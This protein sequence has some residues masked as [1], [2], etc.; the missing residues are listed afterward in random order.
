MSEVPARSHATI[1]EL[2]GVRALAVLAVLAHHGAYG[3]IPGGFLGV[4][5]FFTLSG[6]LITHL[7]VR[8]WSSCGRID[9][10]LFYARRALRIL[11]PLVLAMGLAWLLGRFD[12]RQGAAPVLAFYANYVD[13]L[14]LGTMLHT[15]SLAVEEQFY[16]AWPLL[17]VL[18]MA[19]G[20][21]RAA[22]AVAAAAFMAA[23]AF[24]LHGLAAG[25]DPEVIYRHGLARS[26]ALAAGCLVALLPPVRWPVPPA[27]LSA[28]F[29]AGFALLTLVAVHTDPRLLGPGYSLFAV[30]AALFV[31]ALIAS[32]RAAP[33]K[34]LA[35]WSPLTWIGRRSYGIYL[36]HVPIFV[37]L[38]GFRERQN[39]VNLVLVTLARLALTFLA[40]ELSW[41]LAERPVLSLKRWL[42]PDAGR[43]ATDAHPSGAQ[44]RAA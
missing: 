35:C 12:W 43:A 44:S 22:A 41:R 33:I 10:G 36:Y 32:P 15:W 2:D 1:P 39:I 17:F 7:L 29:V 8:E 18:A 11:P 3:T 28:L 42:Y 34:R 25:M 31:A 37:A 6:F 13:H 27:A 14:S 26:D 5:I 9:L 30:E 20:G 4:D 23:L 16:L 21:K 38:E 24:R 40:A 19:R